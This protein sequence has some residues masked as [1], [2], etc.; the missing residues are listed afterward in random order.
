[1]LNGCRLH[2]S[3]LNSLNSLVDRSYHRFM[4]VQVVNIVLADS[5]RAQWGRG[6]YEKERGCQAGYRQRHCRHGQQLQVDFWDDSGPHQS[7]ES[8]SGWHPET[9]GLIYTQ[10]IS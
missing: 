3:Q 1:M 10:I 2:T 4:A 6:F 9:V 8:L 5:P 7:R